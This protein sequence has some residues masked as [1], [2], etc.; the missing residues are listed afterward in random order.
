M[1]SPNSQPPHEHL[2][3]SDPIDWQ[4]IASD[5]DF[6]KLL[7]SK[8]RFILPAT[9]FFM[10]YYFSFLVMVSWFPD[11]MATEVIGHINIAYLF[12]LSQFFMVWILA[13]LYVAAAAGWDRQVASL[14]AKFS[15]K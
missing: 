9:I 2:S 14:L 12:A 10:V 8:I 6:K 15:H 11:L 4:A 7:V 3:K 13:F 5:T 1:S